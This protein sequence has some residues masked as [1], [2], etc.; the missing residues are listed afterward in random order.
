[1]NLIVSAFL[2]VFLLLPLF[3]SGQQNCNISL[4]ET[5]NQ[6]SCNGGMDGSIRLQV[7]GGIAPYTYQWSNGDDGREISNLGEGIY[8]VTVRDS[9]GC[10]TN[11]QF[12][13][14]SE[15]TTSLALKVV[16]SPASNNRKVLQVAFENGKKP[17]AITTKKISEGFRAPVIAYTGEALGSGTYL[18]EAYN[19]AGCSVMQKVTITGN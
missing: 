18:L 11:A 1:M 19:E 14:I 7:K 8:T 9:Q 2:W 12:K 17:Y 15:N 4:K 10:S 6:V 3:A 16:Q 13:I 5:T